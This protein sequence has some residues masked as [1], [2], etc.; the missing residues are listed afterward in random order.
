[1]KRSDWLNGKKKLIPKAEA[2]LSDV[3]AIGDFLYARQRVI[4]SH[5]DANN[6]LVS[7]DAFMRAMNERRRIELELQRRVDAQQQA[8]VRH[9]ADNQDLNRQYNSNLFNPLT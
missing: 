3:K 7:D 9:Q 6:D 4:S 5:P 8:R 2:D 1:V